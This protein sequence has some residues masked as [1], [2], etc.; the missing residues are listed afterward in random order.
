MSLKSTVMKAELQLSDL[1]RNRYGTF[2]LT[3]A[4]HPR[5]PTC[6]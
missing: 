6:G 1:D 3:L 5:K 2:P 4:Q